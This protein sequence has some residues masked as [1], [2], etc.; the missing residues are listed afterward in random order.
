MK[1]DRSLIVYACGIFF[2]IDFSQSYGFVI[3][4]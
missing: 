2:A 4:T 1:S 3:M